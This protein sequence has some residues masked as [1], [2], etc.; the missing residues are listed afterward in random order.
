MHQIHINFTLPLVF[1]YLPLIILAYAGIGIIVWVIQN[2]FVAIK[3]DYE[4]DGIFKVD[5]LYRLVGYLL[6]WPR[7]LV[8]QFRV[9]VLKTSIEKV[10]HLSGP[11]EEVISKDIQDSINVLKG[12]EKV[13]VTWNP[14]RTFG[15]K[16]I[17]D[18]IVRRKFGMLNCSEL[19]F[20][21]NDFDSVLRWSNGQASN[22]AYAPVEVIG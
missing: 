18:G 13:R 3:S 14:N 12:G 17:Q 16:V 19:I 1:S 5:N 4:K 22:L 8:L 9:K 20:N 11:K 15:E 2:S 7:Y 6:V 21:N 10:M